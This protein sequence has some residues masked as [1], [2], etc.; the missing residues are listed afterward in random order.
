MKIIKKS[1]NTFIILFKKIRFLLKTSRRSPLAHK[2]ERRFHVIAEQN[3]RLNDDPASLKVYVYM[4]RRI[5]CEKFEEKNI[6]ETAVSQ[7][8]YCLSY[9]IFQTDFCSNTSADIIIFEHFS[10]LNPYRVINGI[11]NEFRNSFFFFINTAGK[12]PATPE[13]N[14]GIPENSTLFR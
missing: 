1:Y 7:E 5:A 3:L 14:V 13:I 8:R 11:E 9:G 2:L 4:W 10:R 12:C 6:L